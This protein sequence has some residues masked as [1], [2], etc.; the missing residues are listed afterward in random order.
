LCL[1]E[2][3]LYTLLDCLEIGNRR[4]KFVNGQWLRLNKGVK[5]KGFP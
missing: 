2:K 5:G 3:M 1:G 4:M